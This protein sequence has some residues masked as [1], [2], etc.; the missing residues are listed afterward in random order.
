LNPVTSRTRHTHHKASL[1]VCCGYSGGEAWWPL[2]ELGEEAP[3]Q[4]LQGHQ[5]QEHRH[6][7]QTRRPDVTPQNA[8]DH[9]YLEGPQPQVVQKQGH[10]ERGGIV[11]IRGVKHAARG[12]DAASQLIQYGPGANFI[13]IGSMDGWMD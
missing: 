11:S 1:K 8:D 2:P 10:L 9:R 4:R 12:P 6:A 3:E 7:G 13:K 5:E